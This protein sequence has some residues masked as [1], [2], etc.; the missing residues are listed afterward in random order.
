[1]H[2]EVRVKII[3]EGV[4]AVGES[5]VLLAQASKAIVI[6][7][8]VVPDDRATSMA[9]EK[10]VEIRRYEIIYQISDDVKAALE[11]MLAPETREVQLGKAVVPKVFSISKVGAVAGCRVV[12]GNIERGARM[13]IIRDGTVIGSY[14]IEALKRFKDDVKDVRE[15][16]ECGIKLHNFDDVKSGDVLE[17]FKTEQ[18]KRTID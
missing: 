10:G 17:A 14:P 9:I 11:G 6:A 3:H 5:D 1:K 15:G 16:M 7:F 2:K 18:V 13:R 8:R 12:Q 4:G